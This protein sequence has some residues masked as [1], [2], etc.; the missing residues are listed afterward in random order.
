[1]KRWWFVWLSVVLVACGGGDT[2]TLPTV[3]NSDDIA[4]T[5]GIPPQR[6]F[7]ATQTAR[8]SSTT[9]PIATQTPTPNISPTASLTPTETL[10]PSV[11]PNP[12]QLTETALYERQ[13]SIAATTNAPSPTATASDTPTRTDTPSPTATFT[14][15]TT[16]TPSP[17]LPTNPP[18][19]SIIFSSDRAGTYDLWTMDINGEPVRQIV[20]DP[21][22][23][24]YV[25]AC[26]P[27]GTALIF[28]S[29]RGGDR[30]LYLTDYL[31]IPPRQLTDTE[32]ENFNPVWSPLGNL[33]AF[34]STRSGDAEIWVMDS[35]GGNLRRITVSL[36]DDILPSWS[37]DGNVL[38]YSSNRS[39]NFDI[40]QFNFETAVESQVTLTR[41][42]DELYPVLSTDFQ[43]IAYV[44]ETVFGDPSTGAVFLWRQGQA[45]ARPA[46]T[47]GG[48][49]E[50]PTWVTSD[51]LLV[52]ADIGR[53][54]VLLVNLATDF[55]TLLTTVGN[56]NRWPRYCYIP[57]DIYG[58]LLGPIPT[59]T[60]TPS[61]TPTPTSPFQ[62]VQE[63]PETWLI[64]RETWTGDEM[65]FIAPEGLPPVRGFLTDNLLHITWDDEQGR[66]MVSIALEAYQGELSSTLIGYTL[67]DFPG[68]TE[69][70]IG[71]DELFLRQIL[72]NSVPE[73]AYYFDAVEITDVNITLLFRVPV[74][75]PAPQPGEYQVLEG[76]APNNWLISTET[77]TATE[78]ALL[79]NASTLIDDVGVSIIGT[80]VR[81]Q[82]AD[83]DGV[84]DLIVAFMSA[85]GDLVVNPLAYT[86]NEDVASDAVIQDV[87]FTIREGLLKNSIS[88]GQFFLSRVAMT[89][90]TLEFV[91][92][93]PPR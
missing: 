43:T 70:V 16:P 40:Y 81:Y 84:H 65:A 52:S 21:D 1:M 48:R 46:I 44:A 92:L 82:W 12:I 20:Y 79:A 56:N 15:S 36:G 54:Q 47:A 76:N 9:P 25:A 51:Q 38:F 90:Q 14:P 27:Q 6:A 32:G 8:I 73:G 91:F 22:S 28:D 88:A 67:N 61:I 80:Q 62:A 11:S 49:V 31:G 35:N 24:A 68:P 87:V 85:N 3:A 66:H 77:W 50:M 23:N 41:D 78:L 75:T 55:P 45:S 93:V 19:N 72:F 37:P 7:E 63:P 18:P 39:G 64:S 4:L 86:I 10:T 34:V 26:H 60:L 58:N 69:N 83:N 57:P 74:Q 42:V 89:N 71:L 17:E 5:L 59:A 2:P 13:T 33:V 29:D 30:E 53:V